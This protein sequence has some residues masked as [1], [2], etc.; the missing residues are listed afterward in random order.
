M[1]TE[2]S[3]FTIQADRWVTSEGE[4]QVFRIVNKVGATI[5]QT[6]DAFWADF[7]MKAANDLAKVTD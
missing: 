6:S 4:W 2:H 1:K 3:K 7:I 5:A